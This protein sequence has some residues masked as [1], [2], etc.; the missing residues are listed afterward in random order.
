MLGQGQLRA[1][2]NS[3][4]TLV[5]WQSVID[6]FDSLP[7]AKFRAASAPASPGHTGSREGDLTASIALRQPRG[8]RQ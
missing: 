3:R 6:Y 7:S 1:V 5:V 2:K 8:Q 4:R